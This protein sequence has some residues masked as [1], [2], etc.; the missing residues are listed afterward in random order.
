[1]AE[2]PVVGKGRA[3]GPVVKWPLPRGSWVSTGGVWYRVD[4]CVEH[5]G[6]C[7][8]ADLCLTDGAVSDPGDLAWIIPLDQV[9]EHRDAA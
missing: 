6:R 9:V 4:G 5:H 2:G 8:V 1:M 3:V 7:V